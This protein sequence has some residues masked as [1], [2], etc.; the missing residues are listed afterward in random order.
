MVKQLTWSAY[1]YGIKI[2]LLSQLNYRFDVVATL[3]SQLVTMLATVFLWRAV[4]QGKTTV[5]NVDQNQMVAYAVL[6][7]FLGGIYQAQV[8]ETIPQRMK[9][10]QIV[11]DLLRPSNPLGYWLSDDIGSAFANLLV[12]S[13]PLLILSF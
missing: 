4:Y 3:G 7:A 9:S 2:K 8:Q 5:A 12:R 11:A 13:V 6:S 10:G 1:A